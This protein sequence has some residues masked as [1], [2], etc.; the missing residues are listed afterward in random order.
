MGSSLAKTMNCV[1]LV[2]RLRRPFDVTSLHSLD[3][4]GLNLDTRHHFKVLLFQTH[5][6][7]EFSA[8]RVDGC[9][10]AWVAP[11]QKR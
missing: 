1:L 3:A 10:G 8:F 5:T 11:L 7:M 4:P 9:A 6:S 2:D